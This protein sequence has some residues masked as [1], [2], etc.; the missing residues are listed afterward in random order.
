[1][2]QPLQKGAEMTREEILEK[3]WELKKQIADLEN[4]IVK[5]KETLEDMKIRGKEQE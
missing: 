1:M 2:E 4:E 3:I 5:Y